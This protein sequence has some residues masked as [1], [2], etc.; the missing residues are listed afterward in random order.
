MISPVR[1]GEY[2]F[3]L[4]DP[5]PLFFIFFST[6]ILVCL[7]SILFLLAFSQNAFGDLYIPEDFEPPTIQKISQLSKR[8]HDVGSESIEI[9]DAK[10]FRI[11]E[12]SYNGHGKGTFN[13][14][15]AVE[16]RLSRVYIKTP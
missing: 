1:Y 3:L 9:L 15:S 6:S 10:T 12:L 13:Y 8:S 14:S 5:V 7:V 16:I 4:Q 11:P 2:E